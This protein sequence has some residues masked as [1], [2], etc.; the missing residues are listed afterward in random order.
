MIITNQKSNRDHKQAQEENEINRAETELPGTEEE[1]GRCSEVE[2]DGKSDK[3]F[4]RN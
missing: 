3:S 2:L 4:G 1:K